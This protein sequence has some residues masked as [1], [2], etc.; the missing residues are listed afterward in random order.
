MSEFID[1]DGKKHKI[2]LSKYTTT[3]QNKS[4]LHLVARKLIHTIFSFDKILEEVA[5]PIG[6]KQTLYADFFIASRHLMIEVHGEQ[7]Y[8]HINFFHKTKADFWKAKARDNNKMEWCRINNINLVIL[9]FNDKDNWENL[10]RN[11]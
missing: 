10:I 6:K 5:I 11:A 1:L 4:D 3:H 7:H 8:E 2:N 9:A